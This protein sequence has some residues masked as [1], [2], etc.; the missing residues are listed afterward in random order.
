MCVVSKRPFEASINWKNAAPSL[1]APE[2]SGA[3]SHGQ[4]ARLPE[5]R[6]GP[7]TESA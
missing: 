4:F 3:K 2:R 7:A 5:L 1:E 6:I